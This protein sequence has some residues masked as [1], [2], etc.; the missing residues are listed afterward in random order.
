MSERIV[1]I[2]DEEKMRRILEMDLSEQGYEIYLAQGGEEGIKI[3]QEKDEYEQTIK[4]YENRL[5]EPAK[6]GK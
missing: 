5:S 6:S 2:D 3:L 1:I 4:Y